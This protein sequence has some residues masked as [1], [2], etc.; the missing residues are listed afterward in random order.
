MNKEQPSTSNKKEMIS[1]SFV[2]PKELRYVSSHLLDLI[3]GNL[4]EGTKTKISLRNIKEH[5]VFVLHIEPKSFLV[6][7]KDVNWILAMQDELN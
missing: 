2:P 4:F 5:C 7:E 6:A 1:N 3:I